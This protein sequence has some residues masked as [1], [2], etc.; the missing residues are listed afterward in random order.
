MQDREHVVEL[1]ADEGDTKAHKRTR[2]H[3]L[4]SMVDLERRRHESELFWGFPVKKKGTS[5]FFQ[6]SPNMQHSL[7]SLGEN[8]LL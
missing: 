8:D 3:T 4:K 1:E 7:L 2:R 6:D 5:F